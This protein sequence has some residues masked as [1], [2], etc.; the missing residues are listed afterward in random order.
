MGILSVAIRSGL[1]I[2]AVKYTIDEGAW[3]EPDKAIAF[4]NKVCEGVNEN[5]VISTGKLHF[6]TYVFEFPEVFIFDC[7]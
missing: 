5:Y 1:A 4:K 3:A 7:L 2:Y 6:Q